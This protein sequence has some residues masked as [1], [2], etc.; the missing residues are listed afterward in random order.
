MRKTSGF[1]RM[2]PTIASRRASRY[3]VSSLGIDV[4]QRRFG[5]GVRRPRGLVEGLLYPFLH[6]LF[7]LPPLAFFQGAFGFQDRGEALYRVALAP[8]RDLLAGAVE[9]RVAL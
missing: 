6:P 1:S 8:G 9:V 7:Q 5:L 2:A 4:L 3:V